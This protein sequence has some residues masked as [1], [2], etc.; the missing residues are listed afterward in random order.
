[1]NA[2]LDQFY[3][4]TIYI[5]AKLTEAPLHGNKH[6][7]VS[8]F[9]LHFILHI[10]ILKVLGYHNN[11]YMRKEITTMTNKNIDF[12]NLNEDQLT[13]IKIFEKEFNSKYSSDFF[14]MAYGNK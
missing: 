7:F 1:M 14:I 2:Y 13:A 5:F 12:A 8:A 4:I 10:H 3:F 6:N 11:H 9:L